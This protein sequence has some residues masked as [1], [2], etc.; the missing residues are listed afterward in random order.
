MI[1]DFLFIYVVFEVVFVA[2]ALGRAAFAALSGM[3]VEAI[4]LGVGPPLA[5]WRRVQL[6]AIPLGAFCRV[7]GLD[8][9]ESPVATDDPRAFHNRPLLLRLVVALGWPIGVQALVAAFAAG[10]FVVGGVPTATGTVAIAEVNPGSPADHAGLRPGDEIVAFDGRSVDSA[11]FVRSVSA[12]GDRDAAI[13]VRRDGAT[14]R[15][16]VRPRLVD[17]AYRLGIRIGPKVV[18]VHPGF[19]RALLLGVRM[20]FIRQEYIVGAAVEVYSGRIKAE[21]AGPIGVAQF[22]RHQPTAAEQARTLVDVG[23]YYVLFAL[24]PLPPLPGARFWMVL[25]GWRGRRRR[26]PVAACDAGVVE[27]TRL[28]AHPALL[29]ALVATL[30]RFVLPGDVSEPYNPL[31]GLAVY[32]AVLAALHLPIMRR[33]LGLTCPVCGRLAGRPVNASRRTACMACGSTWITR[34]SARAVTTS[35]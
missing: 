2:G 20:P 28:R 12:V 11:G 10:T 15:H 8:P 30:V 3:R 19:G 25:F 17:G 14:E 5:R 31:L 18:D 13:E 29:A 16:T 35:T 7:A 6:A 27:R 33:S 34:R 1:G 4:V 26:S 21:V 22:I 9:C 23:A 24:L 32:A